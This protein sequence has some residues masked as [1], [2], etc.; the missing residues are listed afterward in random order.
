M[1]FLPDLCMSKSSSTGC[2]HLQCDLQPPDDILVSQTKTKFSLE[3]HV[4]CP[5]G[6]III[7]LY[8]Y[9]GNTYLISYNYYA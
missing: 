1:V 9:N 6:R 7:L 8:I 3:E 2:E 5:S 4:F